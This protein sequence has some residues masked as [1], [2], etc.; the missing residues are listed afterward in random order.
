MIERVILQ[1]KCAGLW[2]DVSTTLSM[3]NVTKSIMIMATIMVLI[4]LMV[5]I[6][7][8]VLIALMILMYMKKVAVIMI[9]IILAVTL[10]IEKVKLLRKNVKVSVEKKEP[11]AVLSKRM[12]VNKFVTVDQL[13]LVAICTQ[14]KVNLHKK[15]A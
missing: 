3:I 6:P 5:L 1:K 12:T 4:V 10:L 14:E 9:I 8:M 2:Q 15:S 11:F 7:L 13:I